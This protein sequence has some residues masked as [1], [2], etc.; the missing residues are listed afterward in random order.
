MARALVSFLAI[1]VVLVVVALAVIAVWN[2]GVFLFAHTNAGIDIQPHAYIH[3]QHPPATPAP[4][5]ASPV[6]NDQIQLKML[7]V[8]EKMKESLDRTPTPAPVATSPPCAQI[9]LQPSQPQ[10]IVIP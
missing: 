10:T 5:A 1:V 3:Y 4:P 6:T 7:E 2:I 8:L 9:A